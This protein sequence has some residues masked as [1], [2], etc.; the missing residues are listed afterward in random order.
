[1]WVKLPVREQSPEDVAHLIVEALFVDS[2]V[3]IGADDAPDL[4]G[5]FGE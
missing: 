2:G 5:I 3:E 1:M 4:A